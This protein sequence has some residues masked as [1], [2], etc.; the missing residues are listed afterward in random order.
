MNIDRD[1]TEELMKDTKFAPL[2]KELRA[3]YEDMEVLDDSDR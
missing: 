3:Q 1:L 2:F